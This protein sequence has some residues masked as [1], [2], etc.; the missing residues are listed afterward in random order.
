[1][2]P[3]SPHS[4]SYT[5]IINTTAVRQVKTINGAESKTLRNPG[6][7]AEWQSTENMLE[8][9]GHNYWRKARNGELELRKGCEVSRGDVA[10][11]VGSFVVENRGAT[12]QTGQTPT[13][14]NA[15]LTLQA[16]L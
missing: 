4:T 14:P 7:E 12:V 8:G 16:L 5:T 6:A 3:S 9:A 10:A 15:R 13:L 2:R 11:R 1:M